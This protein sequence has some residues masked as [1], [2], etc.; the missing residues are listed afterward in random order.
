MIIGLTGG[1]ACGKS[2]VAA[3]LAD[4]G[5]AI[6]DADQL[7]RESA[8]PGSLGLQQIV[9]HFGSDMLQGDGTL[10]RKRLGNV[11]F[12][13]ESARKDL[14]AILHPLIRLK[15]HERMNELDGH[16]PNRL[17]V[18]DV[19]LLYESGM[20]SMFPEI[21]VVYVPRDIQLKRLMQRD[22]ITEEQAQL[23][24]LAQMPI[25]DKKLLADILVDNSQGLQETEQQIDKFW[26]RKELS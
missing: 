9:E 26:Q 13:N 20:D 24:L 15:M 18:V 23:R 14:E 3:M 1:I 10:D 7:A 21:M 2:T 16:Q 5:A 6:V 25:E 8:A 19:P 22:G 4:R 12:N 17:V 11:I